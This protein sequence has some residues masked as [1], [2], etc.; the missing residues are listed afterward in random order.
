MQRPARVQMLVVTPSL[1]AS[2][3]EPR[4]DHGRGVLRPGAWWVLTIEGWLRA[5][6]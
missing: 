1:T 4:K 3:P 2:V 6:L 5:A